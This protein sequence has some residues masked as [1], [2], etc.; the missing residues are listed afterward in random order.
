MNYIFI[1]NNAKAIDLLNYLYFYLY[2]FID[3][4]CFVT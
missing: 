2:I 3:P 1:I 4:F